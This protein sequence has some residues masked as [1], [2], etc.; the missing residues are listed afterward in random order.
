MAGPGQARFYSSTFVQT[1]LAAG[2]GPSTTSFNVGTTTGAPGTPFVVS[3]DQNTASEELM[4]VTNVSGLQYTVTRAV[5]GTA[6]VT[7]ANGAPVVHVMYAQDLTD[8]SAHIGAFDHVH[9]LSVN[10][11][12]VGTTD[13]QTL[14]NKTLTSPSVN[15]GTFSNISLTGTIGVTGAINSTVQISASDFSATGITGITGASRYVGGLAGGPPVSGTFTNGDFFVDTNNDIIWICS[16]NGSPGTWVPLVNTTLAQTLTNKTLT[17]PVI[18]GTATGTG[19][20]NLTNFIEGTN[21]AASGKTG[22]SSA[23]SSYAGATASGAPTTGTF[24]LGDFIIDQ[25]GRI[26]VCTIAGTPGTWVPT[27]GAQGIVAAPT[28]TGSAGTPTVGTTETFDAILGTY[29]FNV[30]SGRRYRVVLTGMLGSGSVA[31]DLFRI[32]IRNSGSS[33]PPT[34]SSTVVAS[35]QW[36]C[37]ISGG[38]GQTGITLTGEFLAGA[39][40]TN[41]IEMSAVRTVGTGV[42]TPTASGGINRNLYVEDIGVF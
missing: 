37:V 21:L 20:L 25:T 33:S 9:G 7:H 31:N 38:P 3:V 35:T 22:A 10:S 19:S 16:V 8:A 2:I 5:G 42:F 14:T 17:S 26:W 1:S 28:T 23:T 11:L 32:L 27:G 12:V 18:G 6:A 39:T 29:S 15:G 40:G 30:I 36:L 41:V 24:A 34:T 4:L 13:I